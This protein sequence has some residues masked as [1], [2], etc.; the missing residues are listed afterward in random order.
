MQSILV[1]HLLQPSQTPHQKEPDIR[2]HP[3]QHA[4]AS[5]ALDAQ[6]GHTQSGQSHKC[7]S[8]TDEHNT[9][10]C[11]CG[12]SNLEFQFKEDSTSAKSNQCDRTLLC[13][14]R[15]MPASRSTPHITFTTLQSKF[16]DA[17]NQVNHV[18]RYK[19]RTLGQP[20]SQQGTP[21]S[22]STHPHAHS[23]GVAKSSAH[24]KTVFQLQSTG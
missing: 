9:T 19:G 13:A 16:I 14:A 21:T 23:A 4:A 15:A 2:Q 22:H 7:H 3:S 20:Q 24:A 11:S 18:C 17:T 5:N 6:I 10:S 12:Q 8:S 1:P